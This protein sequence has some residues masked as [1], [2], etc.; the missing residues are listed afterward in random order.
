[1]QASGRSALLRA[2][3]SGV[4]AHVFGNVGANKASSVFDVPAG[5]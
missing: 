5:T 1:M 2:L 3:R 4:S